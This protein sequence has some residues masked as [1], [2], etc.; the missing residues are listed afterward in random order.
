MAEGERDMLVTARDQTQRLLESL[1]IQREAM[2]ADSQAIDPDRLAAGHDAVNN[3]AEAAERLLNAL[4]S[5]TS[6]SMTR[7]TR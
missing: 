5:I 1:R 6:P 3:A 7:T 2:S 4:A